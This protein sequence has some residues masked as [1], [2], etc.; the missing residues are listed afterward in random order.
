MEPWY[1]LITNHTG[2]EIAVAFSVDGYCTDR[3]KSIALR[4]EGSIDSQPD[5]TFIRELTEDE[6]FAHADHRGYVPTDYN[7]PRN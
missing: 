1:A 4:K 2:A 5:R 7:P 6:F 3:D